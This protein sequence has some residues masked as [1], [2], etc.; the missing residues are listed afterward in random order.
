MSSP[1][2][3]AARIAAG[4][5]YRI[6]YGGHSIPSSGPLLLVANHP[7]SLLDPVLVM[8]AA[9]RPVRFLA[10]APLFSDPKTAWFVRLG[11]AVPVHRASDDPSKMGDNAAMFRAVNAAIAAGDAVGIF[12]EGISH[13]GPAMVPLRTGAARIAL[14]AAAMIGGPFPVIPI[15]LSLRER[16]IFRSEARVI[17][18]APL[19]WD[20]LAASGSESPETV[21]ELTSRMDA[22]LRAVT[23]N[24][25]QWEDAPVIE[26]ATRIWEAERSVAGGDTERTS[27][28]IA[29]ARMLASVRESD[30][31]ADAE[32]VRAVSSFA[33]RLQRLRLRPADLTADTGWWRSAGWAARRLP[34]ALPLWAAV[35]I[36]GWILFIIPWW[37]T[38]RIVGMFPLETDTRSTWKFLIGA[39][40]YTIWVLAIAL[41]VAFRWNPWLGLPALVL[42]PAIGM[43]GLLVRERWH[44]TGSDLR[45]YLL[46]RSRRRL[47][48]GLRSTQRY[49]ADQLESA[50]GRHYD[51]GTSQG[52]P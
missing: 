26:C 45:R 28:R 52:S 12:P 51:P 34:L 3:L 41:T 15:G 47:L 7:N 35:G 10:K 31:P 49:L 43:L 44:G 14:G 11:G 20:D 40:T 39:A 46:I 21:R 1:L 25:E 22:A 32:L 17:A 23:L 36:V 29:A 6:R 19:L 50:I 37:L 24:L 4:V 13:A 27:W 8:A 30:Q 5:Y 18:G 9:R 48:D 2:P 42:V 38:G 16:D 33:T